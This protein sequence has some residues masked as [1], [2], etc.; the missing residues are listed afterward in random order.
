M[1]VQ[2]GGEIAGD[3]EAEGNILKKAFEAAGCGSVSDRFGGLANV[4]AGD[5]D[6]SEPRFQ[7]S[8]HLERLSRSDG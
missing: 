8:A 1:Q 2:S 6:S 5:S 4:A 3:G 7:S